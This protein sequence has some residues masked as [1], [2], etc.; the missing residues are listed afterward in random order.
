MLLDVVDLALRRGDLAS[1]DDAAAVA[2]GDRPPLVRGEQPLWHAELKD[3]A[4]PVEDDL[5]H[6]A[7]AGDAVRDARGH[8]NVDAV[9]PADAS[10]EVI[11]GRGDDE[12]GGGAADRRGRA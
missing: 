2:R 9:G 5:L 8:R 7:R 1:G 12:R 10:V 11:H 4:A 3:L 6:G